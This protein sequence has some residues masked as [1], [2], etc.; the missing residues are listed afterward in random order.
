V[1]GENGREP[2]SRDRICEAAL[3]AIDQGGLEA[4]SMRHLA[5]ALGVKASSLYYH[6]ESKEALMTGVAEFLYKKL[7]RPPAG[8][9]WVDQVR[10]TFLQLREFIESHPNAAPLLIRDL[11]RS[12]VARKRANV[13]LRLLSRAG[14]DEDVSATL[15]TNLVA[16]L[17]GH[18]LLAVWMQGELQPA[19]GDGAGGDG[20]SGYGYSSDP[21]RTW[22]QR[23]LE[24]IPDDTAEFEISADQLLGKSL[25]LITTDIAAP[26]AFGQGPGVTMIDPIADPA[27]RASFLLGL[28]ALIKGFTRE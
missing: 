22:V 23:V 5:A 17:V 2:L 1:S 19:G 15:M 12:P 9:E 8:G 10:G 4:V 13:L 26:M 24:L 25:P 27:P 14:L 21:P 7:G 3:D 28:D 11:A 18:S 20:E 6:F 16:L